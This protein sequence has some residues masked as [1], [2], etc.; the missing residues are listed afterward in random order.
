MNVAFRSRLVGMSTREM[1]VLLDGVMKTL[2]MIPGGDV[3]MTVMLMA[4]VDWA[5]QLTG[6]FVGVCYLTENRLCGLLRLWKL[7]SFWS[8]TIG[9]IIAVPV[10][11]GRHFVSVVLT[12]IEF[13]AAV[14]FDYKIAMSDRLVGTLMAVGILM[15]LALVS[16][17]ATAMFVGGTQ[18]RS[19][20]WW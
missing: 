6:V 3:P 7:L 9:V 1:V 18:L 5:R 4:A 14:S 17:S 13:R 19:F 16:E 12:W 8:L 15:C 11:V 2:L 10:I 20:E